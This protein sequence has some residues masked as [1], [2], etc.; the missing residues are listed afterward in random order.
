MHQIIMVYIPI[1]SFIILGLLP[2]DSEIKLIFPMYTN[3]TS[4]DIYHFVKHD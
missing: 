2:S 4:N 3:S 1:T